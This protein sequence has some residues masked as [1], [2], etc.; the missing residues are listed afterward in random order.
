M[1]AHAGFDGAVRR[2]TPDD[3][4]AV[5]RLAVECFDLEPIHRAALADLLVRR[6]QQDPRLY[7]VATSVGRVVGFAIGAVHERTGF[8]DAI[9]VAPAERRRG[10]GAALLSA[11]EA[12]C[13]EAGAHRLRAGENTWFYAWPGVDLGYTAALGLLDHAGYRETSTVRNMDVALDGWITGVAAAVLR[14]PAVVLRRADVSDLPELDELAGRFEDVWRHEVALAV[15]RDVPT[16]FV[17]V[18]DGRIA[19]FACHGI[20]RADW[21]GPIATDTSARGSGIGEA[22]LRLCLDD[23]ARAGIAV[24]QIGWIGPAGFYSRSVG[25]RCRR[26]FAVLDKSPPDERDPRS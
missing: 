22:L 10:I 5:R 19:G 12:A 4:S 26:V 1:N 21:F 17:A 6:P 23:L 2:A 15:R 11:L 14:D 7:L 24:A 20:Y 9:A 8:L 18:R 16:A 13:A 3:L 25:A